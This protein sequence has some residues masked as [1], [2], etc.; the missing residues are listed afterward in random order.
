MESA[1][2]VKPQTD[3]LESLNPATGEP[4]GSVD[5]IT[6]EQVQDVVDDVSRVQPAWAE[7][8]W[9]GAIV[10]FDRGVRLEVVQACERC[11]IP[12]RDPGT[13]EKWPQL[14]AHLA[15]EH[16]QDLGVLARVLAAG[17]VAEGEAVHITSVSAPTRR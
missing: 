7:L 1:T 13:Q 10:E 17:R 6:P 14:L 8:T 11:A 4:V 12:T 16:G 3:Q 2:A 15:A 5:T 9:P